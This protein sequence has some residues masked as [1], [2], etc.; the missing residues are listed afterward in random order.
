MST[1]EWGNFSEV[2]NEV[3][4]LGWLQVLPVGQKASQ[5]Y[6]FNIMH[7]IPS[8]KLPVETL[9]LDLLINNAISYNRKTERRGMASSANKLAEA[10]FASAEEPDAAR[11]ELEKLALTEGLFMLP[12]YK[13]D[14]CV[15]TITEKSLTQE[16]LIYGYNK[17]MSFLRLK[18]R[19]QVGLTLI[20]TGKWMFAAVL[21]S[22]YTINSNGNPVYLDG[23]AF[24]GLVSLQTVSSTWPA[25]AGL[26]DD[27]CTILQAF[28]RSTF[29]EPVVEPEESEVA[30]GDAEGEAGNSSNK[31]GPNSEMND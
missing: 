3:K 18:Q 12:E 17:C 4:G 13:F 30:T 25:T 15:Y 31:G 1:A 19:P 14:H 24:A 29:V 6:Q 21:A 22:P 28:E 16:G 11:E 7:V 23:F 27:E 2:I 9:P 26:E 8:S 5:P 10:K 20:C